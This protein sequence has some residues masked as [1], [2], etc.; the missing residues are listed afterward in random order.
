M[1]HPKFSYG[2][3]IALDGILGING[4]N[5]VRQVGEQLAQQLRQNQGIETALSNALLLTPPSPSLS[6][7]FRVGD[8]TAHAL[9]WEALVA[10]NDFMALDARWP[11]TRIPRG[12]NT[13]DGAQRAFESPL[14]FVTVISAVGRPGI[15]EWNGLYAAVTQ[16][17]AAGLPIHVTLLAG[18]EKE[19]I[20]VARAVGDNEL[21]VEP[22][23]ETAR[24]LT[25]MLQSLEPHILHVFCHGAIAN[26]IHRLEFGTIRDF[27]DL[28]DGTSSVLVRVDELGLAM[29]N[30]HAWAVVLNTCR[31]AEADESPLTHAEE[32]VSSGVPVAVGMRRLVDAADANVFSAAFY[33]DLFC[34]IRKA[35]GTATA[36]GTPSA[37][38]WADTLV[39][40]RQI[41]R[42]THGA[43]PST[44]DAW[45]LPVLYARKGKFE[46]IP[47]PQGGGGAAATTEEL[48]EKDAVGGM[49]AAL[50]E[51]APPGLADD[52]RA[53]LPPEG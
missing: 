35:V 40:A 5:A 41:L 17:R 11:I 30:A 3:P 39:G 20:D 32:I 53:I 8:A 26:G 42:D 24:E 31:G 28:N 15:E 9:S 7:G 44:N 38:Q 18:E 48:G 4:P 50:S 36:S 27:D 45:T 49:V 16:A 1:G 37:L 33:R 43:D 10:N 22:V 34:L 21:V 52:L 12:G 2:G 51:D 19:V 23:P 13:P 46:L 14:R 29:G 47:P 6:I 25:E